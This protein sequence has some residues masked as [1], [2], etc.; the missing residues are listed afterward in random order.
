VFRERDSEFEFPEHPVELRSGDSSHIIYR[1][2]LQMAG[3]HVRVEHGFYPC[4]GSIPECA[5]ISLDE[6]CDW[7]AA[8]ATAQLLNPWYPW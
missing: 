7:V 3:Y 6:A 2:H 5:S 8:S 1:G 4:E